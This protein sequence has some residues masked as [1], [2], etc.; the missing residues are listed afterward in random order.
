M[1]QK[2]VFVEIKMTIVITSR[3]FD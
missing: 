2:I 3:T 1:N